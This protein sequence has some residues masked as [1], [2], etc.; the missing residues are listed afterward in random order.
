MLI[1]RCDYFGLSFSR[2]RFRV[3]WFFDNQFKT[4]LSRINCIS[5]MLP[6]LAKNE[7]TLESLTEYSIIYNQFSYFFDVFFF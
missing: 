5:N 1:D 7:E 4:S 2:V 6:F 3:S